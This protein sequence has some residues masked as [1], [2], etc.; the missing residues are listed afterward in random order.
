MPRLVKSLPK[1]RKHRASGK[2][3]VTLH[4]TDHYLGPYDSQA[5]KQLYDRLIAEYCT[6]NR[7]PVAR[8]SISV[9]EV[10]H[11]YWQFCKVY[12]V[13]DGKATSEQ[14]AIRW[15]AKSLKQLY[16][17]LPAT[18]F[19][20]LALKA[21]RNVWIANGLSRS[22][23]NQN[24][25][26]IVRMFRWATAEELLPPAV[27]QALAA[28]PGLRQGR[29]EAKESKPVPPVAIHIVEATLPYLRPIVADMVRFQLLTGARPGEV[30][31]LRPVDI[32]R[33][34]DVWEY[35]VGKKT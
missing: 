8:D 27:H 20:P 5:S 31:N 30:C 16:G 22:T 13:K 6:G 14:G 17:S 4:G 2:A 3:V 21:L 35:Q 7:T 32:D 9:L 18:E 25:G 33:S 29:T 10:I 26:R 23:I 24:V 34:H 1:Y 19:G 28:L 11:R 12:Y 15:V